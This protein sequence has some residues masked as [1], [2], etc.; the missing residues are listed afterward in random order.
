MER[1]VSGQRAEDREQGIEFVS[2]ARQPHQQTTTPA[3]AARA[4][5]GQHILGGARI[6]HFRDTH[7][8]FPCIHSGIS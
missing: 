5:R 2:A 7:F 8:P 6:V 3:P 1:P 4:R